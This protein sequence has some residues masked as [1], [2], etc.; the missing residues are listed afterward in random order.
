MTK[1]VI[2]CSFAAALFL[3]DKA[4]PQVNQFFSEYPDSRTLHVP[5]L[6]W[7]ELTNVL[8]T[9][10]RKKMLKEVDVQRITQLLSGFPLETDEAQG[11]PYIRRLYEVARTYGL[12]SYD[13]AYLELAIRMDAQLATL[14]KELITAANVCGVKTQVSR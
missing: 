10:E 11:F 9:A 2:D 13:A 8:C 5:M 12:S 1:W 7:Y 3:P 4:S 14:D 6:W